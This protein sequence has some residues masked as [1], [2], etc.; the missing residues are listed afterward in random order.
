MLRKN[1]LSMGWLMWEA[2]YGGVV[3]DP[4]P[5]F[6]LIQREVYGTFHSCPRSLLYHIITMCL[7]TY[8]ILTLK[9]K[10]FFH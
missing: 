6:L 1:L 3:P 8:Y 10:I 7:F 9:S 5:A 4:L 2:Q